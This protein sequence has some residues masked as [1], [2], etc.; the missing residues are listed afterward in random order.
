MKKTVDI[1]EMDVHWI[2]KSYLKSV[3][4][5]RKK[6]VA[7]SAHSKRI[8]ALAFTAEKDG[9]NFIAYHN[10]AD[11]NYNETYNEIKSE[12]DKLNN[13]RC[14]AVIPKE[15]I[16]SWLLADD[17]AYPSIPE[18]PKLPPKPEEIWGQKDDKNSNYPYNYFVRVLLQFALPDNRDTYTYIAENSDIEVLKQR[19]PVSFCRFY[20]DMQAFVDIGHCSGIPPDSIDNAYVP[21]TLFR[22]K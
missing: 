16:E 2:K 12:F 9:V 10:D 13:F 21:P 3:K 20:T 8:K 1:L 15:M 4:I 11:K 22:K 18:N 5:H 19:C 14:I 6:N 7:I 17:C